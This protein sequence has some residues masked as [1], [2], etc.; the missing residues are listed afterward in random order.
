MNADPQPRRLVTRVD[1]RRTERDSSVR[2]RAAAGSVCV[3]A[4]SLFSDCDEAHVRNL[5]ALVW[6]ITLAIAGFSW[7]LVIVM[8]LMS[9]IS[10]VTILRMPTISDPYTAA[11]LV[12]PMV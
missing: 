8:G 9:S 4:A 2:I 3:E 11:R 10:I 6:G 1:W 5:M 12:P 7:P